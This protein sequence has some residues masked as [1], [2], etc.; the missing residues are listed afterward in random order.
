MEHV[1]SEGARTLFGTVKTITLSLYS[2]WRS[3]V[4]HHLQGSESGRKVNERTDKAFSLL[5]KKAFL[6]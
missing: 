6:F 5:F 2:N 3:G 1:T 4:Q